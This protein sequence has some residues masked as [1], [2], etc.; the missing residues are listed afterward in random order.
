MR[1]FNSS[2]LQSFFFCL[3][4]CRP[5]AMQTVRK[6]GKSQ[7]HWNTTI[8]V[9]TISKNEQKK[10]LLLTPEMCFCSA[11]L[12]CNKCEKTARAAW[13]RFAKSQIS[14][15]ALALLLLLSLLMQLMAC[16]HF[17]KPRNLLPEVEKGGLKHC[18]TAL[19]MFRGLLGI[20]LMFKKSHKGI[21]SFCD[22]CGWTFQMFVRE[23]AHLSSPSI[24]CSLH[25]R[26]NETRCTFNYET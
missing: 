12:K 18:L 13:T 4:F 9:P 11:G 20:L 23:D 7:L 3:I 19:H 10:Q 24:R 17:F 21:F 26:H 6:S 14:A 25:A 8:T 5:S 15:G 22:L 1:L 16:K 2:K